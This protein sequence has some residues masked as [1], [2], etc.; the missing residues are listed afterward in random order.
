MK[1]KNKIWIF[2]ILILLLIFII[3]NKEYNI[4][5]FQNN[6]DGYVINLDTR[7]DRM[8]KIINNFSKYEISLKRFPGIYNK[9]GWKGCGYSHMAVI[10]MAKEK[11][12]PA[13]LILEDDCIPTE[14]FDKWFIIKEWLDK[15]LDKWDVFNGGNSRYS[16]G[17]TD[18]IYGLCKINNDVKLFYSN[19]QAL[20][21]YYINSN[22]YDKMLEWETHINNDFVKMEEYAVDLWPNKQKLKTVSCVPMLALQTP[23]FSDIENKKVDYFDM[24]KKTES[25]LMSIQNNKI[26]ETF[27]NY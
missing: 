21:F 12:L 22:A 3:Y 2:I 5:N 25:T 1:Y 14:H 7:P 20:H 26:C 17:N 4:E 24:I 19:I 8:E 27:I 9:E 15:N 6:N 23:D 18:N 16:A 11:K 10:R 13:V